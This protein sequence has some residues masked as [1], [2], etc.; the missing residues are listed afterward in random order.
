[1]I[2]WTV[3][4]WALNRH[5]YEIVS[6]IGYTPY[7]NCLGLNALD[8]GHP[9]YEINPNECP[10][11]NYEKWLSIFEEDTGLYVCDIYYPKGKKPGEEIRVIIHFHRSLNEYWDYFVTWKHSE[12]G[13]FNEKLSILIMLAIAMFRLSDFLE[14]VLP[15]EKI[16]NGI[17]SQNK[18]M[19]FLEL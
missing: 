12:R 18:K 19:E 1:M 17:V 13:L 10:Y 14:S 4:Q 11:P 15:T 16:I 9:F 8:K 7:N 2:F 6:T 3:Y 5:I